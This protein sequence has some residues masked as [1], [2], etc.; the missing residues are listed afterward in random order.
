MD[1]YRVVCLLLLLTGCTTRDVLEQV[2]SEKVPV[3]LRIQAS[4]VDSRIAS[5]ASVENLPVGATVRV[6]AYKRAS[7]ALATPVDFTVTEPTAQATYEVDADGMLTPCNVDASGNKTAGTPDA[8]WVYKGTY[9]FYAVSPARPLVSEDGKYK[10]N[11]LQRNEDVMTSFAE[12]IAVTVSNDLVTLGTFNRQSARVIFKVIPATTTKIG[13][14]KLTAKSVALSSMSAATGSILSGKVQTITPTA[15]STVTF[16]NFTAVPSVD[17]PKALG[18]TQEINLVLPKSTASMDIKVTF[19]YQ[20]EN[21][22]A[23]KEK[24][25][26]A[27]LNAI[28]FE[29]GKS[30]II[31]LTVDNNSST[32]TW[33]VNWYTQVSDTDNNM[34]GA[35]SRLNI[36]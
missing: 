1:Y 11:G 36:L 28:A 10:V 20:N 2:G 16:S 32:L 18:L 29:A 17:D 24:T 25:F 21:E 9:D 13:L 33:T 4:G 35:S 31:S 34:G 14:K 22:A 19:D 15:A 3:E 27:T 8:F 23:I 6:A 5:R 7:G 26:L 12:G 30:Y